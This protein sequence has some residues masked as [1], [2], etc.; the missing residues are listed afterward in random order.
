MRNCPFKDLSGLAMVLFV[1][2]FSSRGIVCSVN[3]PFGESSV[4]E[5]SSRGVVR[6]GIVQSGSCL[7]GSCPWG[8]LSG[9]ELSVGELSVGELSVG[10]LPVGELSGYPFFLLDEKSGFLVRIN[11]KL[12]LLQIS[13][14]FSHDS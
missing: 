13:N 1:R 2:S 6:L 4:Q 10:E 7:S 3:C 11:F 8:E 12:N 5:L 14:Y 9:W